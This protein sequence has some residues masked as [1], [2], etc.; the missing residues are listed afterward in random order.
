MYQLPDNVVEIIITQYYTVHPHRRQLAERPKR[1]KEK[2]DGDVG[3]DEGEDEGDMEEEGKNEEKHKELCIESITSAEHTVHSKK[4]HLF[5]SFYFF[6]FLSF[7]NL[8][9][10]K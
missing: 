2:E 4:T 10:L 8:H 6:F 3:E 9:R 5:L 7:G 1:K